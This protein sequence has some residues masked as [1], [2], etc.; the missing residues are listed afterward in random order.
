V[1]FLFPNY[2]R[3]CSWNVIWDCLSDDRLRS[4]SSS[5]F[6]QNVFSG[7]FRKLLPRKTSPANS[8]SCFR[9]KLLLS[10]TIQSRSHSKT[11][12]C[13]LASSSDIMWI[14]YSHES[15]VQ[16]LT[17]NPV[18]P[19]CSASAPTVLLPYA[20]PDSARLRRPAH[21][22]VNKF[23]GRSRGLCANACFAVVDR[24]RSHGKLEWRTPLVETKRS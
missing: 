4:S 3:L 8:E 1:A 18:L 23:K 21:H 17:P 24:A 10:F 16:P 14:I 2:L 22:S 13:F 15:S 6:P 5:R 20:A 9:G 12:R 19:Y 7:Q 11:R